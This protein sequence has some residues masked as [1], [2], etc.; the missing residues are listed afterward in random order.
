MKTISYRQG[1]GSTTS[2]VPSIKCFIAALSLST[3]LP[4]ETKATTIRPV[5][6]SACNT[7]KDSSLPVAQY[8][9]EGA[10][11][12]HEDVANSIQVYLA[13]QGLVA[14]RRS[15]TRDGSVL[16]QF[17]TGRRS[18]VDVYPTGEIVVVATE[19]DVD[20]IFELAITDLPR[21]CELVRDGFRES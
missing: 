7:A 3:S 6:V 8:G 2:G 17:L 19:N 16:L 20:N 10:L 13:K 21:I 18:C 12:S 9:T 5:Y 11:I 15:K 14:D 1:E 4:A